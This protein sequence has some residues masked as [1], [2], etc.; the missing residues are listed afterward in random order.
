MLYGAEIVLWALLA[1]GRL[2]IGEDGLS[3]LYAAFGVGGILAASSAHRVAD[4][5]RQGL[6]LGLATLVTGMSIAGFA[7]THSAVVGYLLVSIDGAASIVL[8][9]LVLTSLQRMLGND[10]MGRA[11]GAVDSLIVAAMLLGSIVTPPLVDAAGVAG[12]VLV[13]GGV[14]SL[15][16]LLVL[17]RA[18]A[19]DRRTAGRAG[20]LEPQVTLLVELDIFAGA[21][22]ATLEALA[23]ELRPRH[24]TAGEVVIREG[25]EPDD[26][27]L[28]DSGRLLVTTQ[29]AG[30]V[31]E[32][33]DRNYFGEIGL[34]QKVPRIATVMAAEASELW[35]MPGETFLRLVNEGG[36]R[37][38]S[39]RGNMASRLASTR[40]AR[41]E[42]TVG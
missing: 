5:P 39:L 31:A 6:I 40:A 37:S 29:R 18:R 35:R 36:H 10:V 38:A 26:L 23:A 22:R 17:L 3:F 33:G 28:V 32:L 16:G 27:Y 8:D 34:L 41:R 15:A 25:D 4:R 24:V 30:R 7:F 19:I 2:G 11:I 1:A 21:S 42:E 14:V 12:A 20:E 9:V 13:V